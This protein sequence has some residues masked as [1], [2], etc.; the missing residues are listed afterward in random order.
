LATSNALTWHP[1][2][3]K[4]K[5]FVLNQMKHNFDSIYGLV[6]VL[7]ELQAVFPS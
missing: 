2:N 7:G 1:N 3:G 6:C 4:V 5:P